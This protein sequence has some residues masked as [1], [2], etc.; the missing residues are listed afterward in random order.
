MSSASVAVG[1]TVMVPNSLGPGELMLHFGTQAQRDHW[2]PRLADGR[3]IP[4]FGLTSDRAGSDA[5]AMTDRGVVAYGEFEGQ[6]TLG[7]RL[8]FA[9]RYITLAPVATVMGLA[10]KLFDPEGHLGRGEELGITVALIPTSTPGVRHGDRHIP[11]FTF[12]QNGPLY[13]EDVFIPMDWILGGEAQIGEGWTM[14]MKAL[15]TGRGISLPRRPPPP[16]R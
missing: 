1:V 2:L 12:F 3:E 11:Q 7:I 14:L 8:N 6:R 10:F 5:A 4:C 9:K 15:A 16:R 13:G